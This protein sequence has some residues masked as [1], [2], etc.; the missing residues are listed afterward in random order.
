MIA[1]LRVVSN[2]D[3]DVNLL[4]V[5]NTPRR[6]IGKKTI[7]IVGNIARRKNCSL[8]TAINAV[9]HAADSPLAE[10]ARIDLEGFCSLIEEYRSRLLSRKKMA[11][12]VRALLEEIDYWG[13]LVQEH[14]KNEKVP[15]WRYRNVMLFTDFIEEWEKDPDNN[16]PNI[17]AYL[18][19]ITLS[20]R[21]DVDE[22][23][24]RGK[25]N[26][27]TI[28]SAKGLEFEV[29]FLAGVEDH[30]IPHARA[31]EEDP[32]NIEEE[33]RLFYV[34]ITRAREKL[35][36][37]SCRKRRSLRETI[38]CSPSPFL[39]ELPPHLLEHREMETTTEEGEA[40]DFFAGIKSRF[41]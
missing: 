34:A 5:I 10:R 4:R 18:N 38:D 9:R 21:D 19:R 17:Y 31:I 8:Y 24:G 26:L 23:G 41:T 16:D 13:Y 20:S 22:E 40:T 14:P 2:P 29:V 28:H 39:N 12:S 30:L 33:R 6:G 3:D 7:E 32:A 35:I 37:S 11:D 25:V 27:M 15:K 1:Y 36:V